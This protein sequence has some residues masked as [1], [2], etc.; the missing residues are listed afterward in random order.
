MITRISLKGWKSHLDSELEFSKGVNAIIGIMGS[1]KTSIMDAISFSLYGTFPALQSRKIVLDDLIMRKPQKK[2]KAELELDFQANGSTY[3]IKK[4]IELEKGT[5]F[6]EI[7]KD[8][9]L[10]DVNPAS[11]TRQ[12]E[13]ILQMDY[14]LFS[15]AVYSEQ[16]GLDYF[17]RVPKGQRMQQIDEMLKVDRFETG[18]ESA[19]SISNKITLGMKEKAR[20]VATLEKEM[21]ADRVQNLKSEIESLKE[22]A[23]PMKERIQTLKNEQASLSEKLSGFERLE[24]ESNRLSREL[25]GAK[26]AINELS[27]S[28]KNKREDIKGKDIADVTKQLG[29][30]EEG[31]KTSEEEIHRKREVLMEQKKQIASVDTKID[32]IDQ[33]IQDLGKLVARCPVCESP[34]TEDKKQTLVKSR[35]AERKSLDLELHDLQDKIAFS[36]EEIQTMERKLRQSISEREKLVHLSSDLK[37]IQE[38]EKR[39]EEKSNQRTEL[40][41]NLASL[42]KEMASTDAKSARLELQE[43]M[44]ESRGLEVRLVSIREKIMDR[45][46]MLRD[47][48]KRSKLL[49]EYKSELIRDGRAVDSL[50]TFIKVLKATQDQLREEFLKTV[51]RI[52]ATV[53]A[54]LYPYADFSGIRLVIDKDYILQLKGEEGWISVD[55]IASGGERSMACLA[56]RIAFSLA[57]IPNLRWLILDEPTHNLDANAISQFVNILQEKMPAF[58]EQVFIITHDDRISEGVQGVLY[59]LDRNKNENGATQVKRWE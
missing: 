29:A 52:M 7:R 40:E 28:L 35:K 14:D 20:L 43:K 8:G 48:K 24:S 37:Q 53:W 54:E 39:L 32:L 22:E 30:M 44:A 6:A 58:A 10:L 12:V 45:D 33:A 13:S 36:S 26:S 16:N 25:Q 1:G 4:I 11:V 47:L 9:K 55:G 3:S 19:V 56:L 21:L 17:L 15:R 2:S 49:E 41:I 31:I 23:K 42:E 57:F 27:A 5:T 51:N 18:R 46:D 50:Q 59:R 34:I 38:W